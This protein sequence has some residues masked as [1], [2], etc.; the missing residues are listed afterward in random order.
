MK[1][2]LLFLYQT[3]ICLSD[4]LL[5]LLARHPS[6]CKSAKLRAFCT[7]RAQQTLPS[8]DRSQPV[9]WFHAA[10]MGE[11]AAVRPIIRAL[12]SSSCQIVVTFFSPTGVHAVE[13]RRIG[14]AWVGYL[15][16]DTRANVT[17]FLQ[18][19]R[20]SAA[21]FSMK[22]LWPNMLAELRR[23]DIPAYLVDAY[24]RPSMKFFR[25]W[26]GLFC[27]CLRQFTHIYALDESTR[28][29]L[30]ALGVHQCTVTGDPLFDQAYAV[31]QQEWHDP[32]VERFCG[33]D[34]IFI[35]G[36]LDD[37]TDLQL[38]AQ[39]INEHPERRFLVIPH[40]IGSHWV[41]K[42]E[43]CVHGRS[44]R[45]TTCNDDTPLRSCQVLIVNTVGMLP[46]LYRYARWAYVGGG[47]TPLIHSLLEPAVYGLPVA[48]GPRIEHMATPQQLIDCGVGTKICSYVQLHDWYVRCADGAIRTD[49]V[50]AAA[51]HY[52]KQNLGATERIVKE[53]RL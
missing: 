10:S 34:D 23:R 43:E 47:F 16:I 28:Q 53:I 7:E 14:V 17:E 21:I 37:Q 20:P 4:A 48:F 12:Q 40:E 8:L 27:W 46:Y 35:V 31:A 15:P 25:P 19:L 49:E 11:F 1:Y 6:W 13:A 22:E 30:S 44:V 9:Y 26:G 52:V 5:R 36:S 32:V 38:V 41:S 18:E 29:S 45:Y 3:V 51:Q 2:G 39:L 33:E 50:R 42:I 24:V